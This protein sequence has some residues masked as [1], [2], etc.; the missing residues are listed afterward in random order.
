MRRVVF[1]GRAPSFC[2][3]KPI[4]R[5]FAGPVMR[6]LSRT[7]SRGAFAEGDRVMPCPLY[8]ITITS[9]SQMRTAFASL[10]GV[11]KQEV[12]RCYY[13]YDDGEK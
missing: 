4:V 5:P 11:R 3:L 6:L 7:V 13:C 1:I 2:T 10:V 12:P 8:A 9:G